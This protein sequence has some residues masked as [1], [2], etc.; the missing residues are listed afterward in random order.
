MDPEQTNLPETASPP[1]NVQLEPPPLERQLP[2]IVQGEAHAQLASTEPKMTKKQFVVHE[3]REV[4]CTIVYLAVSLSLVATFR[5]LVLIQHGINDFIHSYTV[6]IVLAFALGKVV[7][8]AQKLPLISAFNKRP[9]LLAV[10][11]KSVLMTM[12]MDVA[13]NIEE[14]IFPAMSPGTGSTGHP[15]A[16]MVAHQLSLMS[17]FIVLFTFRD[18][19]RALGR[20]TLY[21]LFF[22]PNNS[23]ASR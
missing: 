19:D 4:F 3:L 13:C 14:R 1:G 9:L 7:V 8:I 21:R 12:I 23:S 10:M 17:I 16:L 2:P 22:H 5:S 15:I 6:A 18:L 11:Y 20:G